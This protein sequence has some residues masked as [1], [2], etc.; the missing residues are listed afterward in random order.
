MTEQVQ[1]LN[2]DIFLWARAERR[3]MSRA[4]AAAGLSIKNEDKIKDWEEGKSA[5]TYNQLE[6][7]ADLYGVPV[8]VFF[9]SSRPDVEEPHK[10]LRRLLSEDSDAGILS[11][12]VLQ[13]VHRARAAQ[14]A[15]REMNNGVNP[16]ANP[17]HKA[18]R[19][20]G[21]AGNL[22]RAAAVLRGPGYF[23]ISTKTQ[24][25][26]GDY[27]SA[28]AGWRAAIESRGVY[29]FQM[30]FTRKKRAPKPPSD[31]QG[32]TPEG[33]TSKDGSSESEC[34]GFCLYDEEFPVICLN[35]KEFAGR[36]CFTLMHELA[37]LLR[38]DD[39]L[40]LLSG[41]ADESAVSR[42]RD[43]EAERFCDRF[44]GNVLIPDE[45][46]KK[47]VNAASMG[48]DF[49]RTL[50]R[51]YWV[52]ESMAA[53]KCVKAGLISFESYRKFIDERPTLTKAGTS[54]GGDHYRNHIA[55]WGKGFLA[56]AFACLHQNRVD[57]FDLCEMLRIKLDNLD[58]LEDAFFESSARSG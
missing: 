50:S 28:L 41:R 4:D 39:A 30:P 19:L 45:D 38:G 46:I 47:R 35:S 26:W 32:E 3:N 58:K 55:R 42:F 49:F 52:S 21:Y 37:H 25:D 13:S 27:H 44:A 54:G 16:I 17:L 20:S 51:R 18:F 22:A 6:K 34:S 5:P 53:V 15:L 12:G 43:A 10:S 48:A 2:G 29:V 36:R 11:P 9:F 40:T 7:I 56:N 33:A 31:L 57:R 24:A 23:N 8:A 1:H 14:M